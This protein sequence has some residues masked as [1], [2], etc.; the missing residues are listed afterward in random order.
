MSSGPAARSFIGDGRRSPSGKRAVT[1]DETHASLTPQSVN[2]TSRVGSSLRL[3]SKTAEEDDGDVHV[4]DWSRSYFRDGMRDAERM[5]NRL[6]PEKDERGDGRGGDDQAE[7]FNKVHVVD[8]SRSYFR[9]A[10]RDAEK[11]ENLQRPKPEQDEAEESD[12]SYVV[13]WWR[14]SFRDDMRDAEW[15]NKGK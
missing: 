5:R 10:V 12:D 14:S 15:R 3:P 13:H 9:D 4:V 7:E 2:R 1:A 6:G 8:W 11:R